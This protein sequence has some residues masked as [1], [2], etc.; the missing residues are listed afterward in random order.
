MTNNEMKYEAV[1]LGLDLAKAIGAMLVVI[2]CDSQVVSRHING[3]YEAKREW[4]RE[5]LSII[6]GKVSKGL[7]AKFVLIP[8]EENE[9]V[10]HLAKAASAECMVVT[11]QVL[12]FV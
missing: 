8:K 1:L 6:K 12:S 4:M 3:D 9:Q 2:H 11:N 10:D 5:Y 7:S